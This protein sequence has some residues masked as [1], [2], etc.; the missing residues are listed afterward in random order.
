[1][2]PLL[3]RLE[4]SILKANIPKKDLQILLLINWKDR[5][6]RI[7]QIL[8]MIILDKVEIRLHK[9]NKSKLRTNIQQA[10]S[11][12]QLSN[13]KREFRI[14]KISSVNNLNQSTKELIHKRW[15]HLRT[16]QLVYHLREQ[17]LYPKRM[18]ANHQQECP[19]FNSVLAIMGKHKISTLIKFLNS[20]WILQLPIWTLN[21]CQHTHLI[22]MTR[23]WM[24]LI[25]TTWCTVIRAMMNMTTSKMQWI[26]RCLRKREWGL[27]RRS[28]TLI[29][30]RWKKKSSLFKRREKWSPLWRLLSRTRKTMIW[31]TT[32]LVQGK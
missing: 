6:S 5:T 3:C 1:M 10:N 28:T 8:W 26:T 16:N 27:K 23:W 20:W 29:S 15:V 30:T 32:Y 12:I 25:T 4:D 17:E 19:N 2:K 14:T 9:N 7:F 18:L 11:K 24:M 13:S 21:K 31:V 22:R